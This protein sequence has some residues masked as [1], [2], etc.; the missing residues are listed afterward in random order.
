MVLDIAKAF[1]GAPIFTSLYEPALTFPEYRELN[2]TASSLNRFRALRAHHRAAL[3]LLSRAVSRM[4]VDSDVLVASSSGWAHGMKTTGRKIIYCHAPAR[5]LYQSR[6]Y[7]GGP[8][9]S[10]GFS[11]RV[12]HAGAAAGL[13]AITMPLRRWDRKAAATADLYLANSTV[14]QRAIKS[15]YGI[16][17]QII[18]PPPAM[19]PAGQESPLQGV[20]PG[21]VL[22]V[23]RLL[24]YKN[25]DAVIEAVGRIPGARLVIVGTGPDESRLRN[26]VRATANGRVTFAGRVPDEQLRWIYRNT[27][28]LMAASIEDYGLTPL[29]AAAFGKP[30]V[31]L[32]AGG[33][34]D[35]IV[36]D[37][38]G[39]FFDSLDRDQ[40]AEALNH[41]LAREWPAHDLRAHAEA[42][43]TATFQK[44]LRSVVAGVLA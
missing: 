7:L 22:C 26:V 18:P 4:T 17:A 31:A 15:A 5:W 1:P 35:T 3:P 9:G 33:F 32:R 43:S 21:F 36:E 37:R 25:V 40:M 27:G 28:A 12:R 6:T 14:T 8:D 24:P 20:E 29:E 19:L 16:D 30:S 2:V 44:R 34:L 23:A 38:T 10:R 11:D 42:F 39:V 13:G 41:A